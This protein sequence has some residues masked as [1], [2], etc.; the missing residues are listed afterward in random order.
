MIWFGGS[1]AERLT[2]AARPGRRGMVYTSDDVGKQ[3]SIEG[4]VLGYCLFLLMPYL[5]NSYPMF[6]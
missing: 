2:T 5:V 4:Q 3:D 6:T 1:I